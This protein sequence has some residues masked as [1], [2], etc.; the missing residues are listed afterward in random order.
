MVQKVFL[1]RECAAMSLVMIDTWVEFYVRW[2]N[3]RM[4]LG[5]SNQLRPFQVLVP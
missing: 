5:P 3:S 2:E 4:S 1:R